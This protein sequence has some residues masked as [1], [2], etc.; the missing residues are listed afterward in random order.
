MKMLVVEDDLMLADSLA[1][2]LLDDGHEVC[3]IASRVAEAVALARLHRPD[4]ALLDMQLSKGEMG[5]DIVDRLAESND[6]GCMGIL[7]VTGG[8]GLVHQ[9]AHHGHAILSKPYRLATLKAAIRAVAELA[10]G[11]AMTGE[12]PREVQILSST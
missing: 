8:A 10:R 12:L 9:A 7:Y 11:H 1:D 2:A 3:G 4:V 5:T 6:L